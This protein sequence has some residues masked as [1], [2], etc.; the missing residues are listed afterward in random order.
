MAKRITYLTAS[1]ALGGAETSLLEIVASL[2][3]EEPHWRLA[4]VAPADGPLVARARELGVDA[5]VLP[6]PA[7]LARLG[8]NVADEGGAAIRLG[9]AALATAAHVRRLRQALADA[10]PDIVHANG[11]KAHVL[12]AL[13]RPASSALVW[14]VHD[15]V[16]TRPWTRR[17]LK[18]TV[19]QA[20]AIIANSQSVADDVRA[21]LSPGAPVSVL[22][23][24]VDLNRFTPSGARLDLDASAGLPPAARDTVRVGLVATFGRWKGHLTFL[25]A[26]AKLP[27][28]MPIRAYVIGDAVY[29]TRR[30]QHTREEFVAAAARLG[31][32]DRVGFTGATDDAAA[33]MRA[34]DVVVHA[35]TAP[36]PFGMVIA[37]AMA[38]GRAVIAS[39]AGGAAEIVHDEVDALG[40]PPGDAHV[41]AGVIARLVDDEAL[42]AR[43]GRAARAAAERRFDR[44]RLAAE[45][46]PL[47]R[48]LTR[49]A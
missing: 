11:F 41:L 40:H 4:L 18:R 27:R 49:A 6:F 32:G 43:L 19:G 15:Y 13:A 34:L 39:L 45:L 48:T 33:A 3:R 17:V 26:I 2:R 25:D 5:C 28:A 8:E 1:G 44:A 22:Y 10:R 42:R 46:A 30:S 16:G 38:C 9:H 37:E 29:Q 20:S 31:I 24:A 36:E 21:A 47:Y 7:A 35:S 23:N 12:G 14:H